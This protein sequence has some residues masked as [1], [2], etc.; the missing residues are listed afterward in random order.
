MYRFFLVCYL[1]VNLICVLQTLLKTPNW[2][3]RFRYYH[4]TLAVLGIILNLA[5][6]VIAGWYYALA[7][8]A[9]AAFIYKYIEY[10]GSALETFSVLLYMYYT[11]KYFTLVAT[12]N[13]NKWTLKFSKTINRIIS[14]RHT[15]TI[16]QNFSAIISLSCR[17]HATFEWCF[18]MFKCYKLWL[19]LL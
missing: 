18:A 12:L 9:I 13:G 7:A 6:S 16:L 19:L 4:W 10:K 1:F 11:I 2:R 14:Y 8:F 3:P 5:L 17:L 15:L